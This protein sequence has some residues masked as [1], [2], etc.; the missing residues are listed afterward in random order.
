MYKIYISYSALTYHFYHAFIVIFLIFKHFGVYIIAF[1]FDKNS[2]TVLLYYYYEP[3]L[4]ITLHSHM[5][6]EG[7]V[8]FLFYTNTICGH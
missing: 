4:F 6:L 8:I 2:T 7:S 3:Y 1:S 5:E